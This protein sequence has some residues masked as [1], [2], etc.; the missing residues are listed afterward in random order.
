MERGGYKSFA[1]SIGL[2]G[3]VSRWF[4]SP[5]PYIRISILSL[6]TL[7]V[8][9][10][11][12][13]YW[14][15]IVYGRTGE[16]AILPSIC[17]LPAV[18][19]FLIGFAH[20]KRVQ[21]LREVTNVDPP[22]AYQRFHPVEKKPVQSRG[23]RLVVFGSLALWFAILISWTSNLTPLSPDELVEVIAA[24]ERVSPGIAYAPLVLL[25]VGLK[26]LEGGYVLC[27]RV[28]IGF[29]VLQVVPFPRWLLVWTTIANRLVLP[30]WTVLLVAI[31]VWLVTTY[32]FAV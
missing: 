10:M 1:R 15:L 29:L 30:L 25:L 5:L 19:V 24:P 22:E 4:L 11:V 13:V 17:N 21:R 12:Q 18:L 7:M 3:F 23:K 20:K 14:F 32:P 2:E 9:G 16:V 6:L 28:L 31:L 8:W 26:I 27:A